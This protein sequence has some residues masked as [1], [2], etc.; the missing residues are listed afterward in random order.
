MVRFV[1]S[2]LVDER[3]EA[4][5]STVR[6]VV[7]ANVG[8]VDKIREQVKTEYADSHLAHIDTPELTVYANRA[9]FDEKQ[10]PLAANLVTG[11]LD[12][13]M[14]DAL[15]VVVPERGIGAVSEVKLS[16]AQMIKEP[17]EQFV[18]IM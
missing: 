15:V 12:E 13:T 10:Q 4:I 11:S 7:A 9:A 17:H 3:D 6:F 14:D 2:Q 8:N 5:T 1:W 16:T 18:Q